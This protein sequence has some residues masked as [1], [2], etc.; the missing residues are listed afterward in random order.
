MIEALAQWLANSQALYAL[1]VSAFTSATILPGTSEALLTAAIVAQPEPSRVLLLVAIASL[2][3]TLGSMT[4]WAIGRFV[5]NRH[6]E[7]R[8]VDWLHRHGA[9]ILAL[10]W[11]PVVGDMLPLAAGWVRIGF[12]S[13]LFW[14]AVGKLARYSALAALVVSVP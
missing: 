11:V 1:A 3:N 13:A 4:S 14:L 8:A 6:P 2:C 5:P 12:W 10:A 9:W 7:A